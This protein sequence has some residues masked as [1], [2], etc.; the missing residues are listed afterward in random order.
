MGSLDNLI[1]S[2]PG[3]TGAAINFNTTYGT[4]PQVSLTRPT[5]DGV[6]IQRQVFGGPTTDYNTGRI[7]TPSGDGLYESRNSQI[8]LIQIT[9]AAG[10]SSNIMKAEI[11][12]PDGSVDIYTAW[13]EGTHFTG[14]M[15]A[16]TVAGQTFKPIAVFRETYSG[17]QFKAGIL[18]THGGYIE[19]NI[20]SYNE[21]ETEHGGFENITRP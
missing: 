15:P 1:I 2:T 17:S 9:D 20:K 12:R 19:H 21:T 13:R 8:G 4:S 18:Q 6:D 5:V 10:V 16:V 14:L 11:D 3:Q 7:T